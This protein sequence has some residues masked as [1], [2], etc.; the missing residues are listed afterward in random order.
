MTPGSH[1]VQ[2]ERA[3]DSGNAPLLLKVT[4]GQDGASSVPRG[5]CAARRECLLMRFT[6][7]AS[8]TG[9]GGGGQAVSLAGNAPPGMSAECIRGRKMTDNEIREDCERP[10]AR[11]GTGPR[12]R[13]QGSE[14]ESV[15]TA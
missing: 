14:G 9:G 12:G 5:R 13:E 7:G 2:P 6:G 1:S 15:L 8:D 4:E 10:E 3:A 11:T